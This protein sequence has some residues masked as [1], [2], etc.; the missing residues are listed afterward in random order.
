MN[1]QRK[2]HDFK[3]REETEY[4]EVHNAEGGKKVGT[5]NPTNYWDET[6]AAPAA[7]GLGDLYM[8]IND[9]AYK[10]S[11]LTQHQYNWHWATVVAKDGNDVVTVEAAPGKD[12]QFQMYSQSEASQSF[13]THYEKANLLMSTAKTFYLSH[14]TEAIKK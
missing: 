10:K 3:R 6:V 13:Q 14:H 12:V 9:P 4:Y 7:P 1:V 5:R 11:A 2:L 8:V